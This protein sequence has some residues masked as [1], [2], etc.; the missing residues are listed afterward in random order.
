MLKKFL[1]FIFILTFLTACN[2]DEIQSKSVEWE[3]Y[4]NSKFGF[5]VNYPPDWNIGEESDNEDG[6]NLYIGNPDVQILAFA[7]YYMEEISN[8]YGNAEND[9]F[10]IQR[11]TLDNGKSADLIVGKLDQMVNYELVFISNDIIYNVK[12]EVSKSFFDKNEDTLL[13]VVKSLDAL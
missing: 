4:V 12:A 10:D 5:S 7:S 2:E 6:I 13:K 9:G 1:S 11:I 8:P 3:K